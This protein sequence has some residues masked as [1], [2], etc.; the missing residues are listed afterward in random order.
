TGVGASRDRDRY[1]VGGDE[2]H[3]AAALVAPQAVAVVVHGAG[4]DDSPRLGARDRRAVP[5]PR[6]RGAVRVGADRLAQAPA[7]LDHA[8]GIV[9][10]T[11]P[12]VEGPERALADAAGAGRERDAVRA[13]R[14]PADQ[15]DAGQPRS[16]AYASSSSRVFMLGS[17]TTRSSSSSSAR[18]T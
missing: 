18:P 15:L 7:V 6:H 4:C 5:L 13:G 11:D 12:E 9:L 3:R 2:E 10:R 1:A 16:S 14:V 17:S 8:R